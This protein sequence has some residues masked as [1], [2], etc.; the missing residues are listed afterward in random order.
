[1][2]VEELIMNEIIDDKTMIIIR[3]DFSAIATGNWFQDDILD[4]EKEEVESFIWEK[5]V[6]F[7]IIQID[8]APET[9]CK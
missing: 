3:R 9:T 4:Y 1:M 7:N 5:H 8:L 2:T 6:F